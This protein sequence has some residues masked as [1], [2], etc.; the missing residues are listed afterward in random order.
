MNIREA[1]E[2]EFIFLLQ[3]INEESILRYGSLI[4]ALHVAGLKSSPNQVYT[5]DEIYAQIK[6]VES[7]NGFVNQ[8]V[9]N[10]SKSKPTSDA[11]VSRFGSFE[12][13]CNLAGVMFLANPSKNKEGGNKRGKVAYSDEEIIR[14]LQKASRMYGDS[15]TIQQYK[16]SKLKP[17]YM[18]I[19]KRYQSFQAAC[20]AAG[21]EYRRYNPKE[22]QVD[23]MIH[24]LRQTFISAGK[25]LTTTEYSRAGYSPTAATIYKHGI[26][27]PEAVELAGFDYHQSKLTGELIHKPSNDT[28]D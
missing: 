22:L 3:Q 23:Q 21:I 14:V 11:I 5:N 4:K 27:W 18:T 7:E 12:T 24:S 1:T 26:S 25:M 16:E 17:S 10:K 19:L 28:P 6:K 15:L 20:Q 2:E 13:A 8:A 9:Y